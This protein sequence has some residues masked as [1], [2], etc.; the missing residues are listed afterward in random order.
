[1]ALVIG[2]LPLGHPFRGSRRLITHEATLG[3]W[4]PG[5]RGVCHSIRLV[6]GGIAGGIGGFS[7]GRIS[8]ANGRFALDEKRKQ[9]PPYRPARVST[10]GIG[11]A[12]AWH[13]CGNAGAGAV[14]GL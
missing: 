6:A 5:I 13:H 1:M 9:C 3:R 11:F 4:S 12:T 2:V 10:A 14:D 8:G 7:A